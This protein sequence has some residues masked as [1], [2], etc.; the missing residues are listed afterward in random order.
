MKYIFQLTIICAIS[1]GAE[2]LNI[3]LPLPIPASVYGLV[4]L[5]L[6]LLFHVMKLEQ[7]E[8]VADFFITIMP[9]FFISSSVSLIT[10][11]PAMQGQIIP[12]ILM[13][14]I[15][16]VGTLCVTG[17]VSQFVIFLQRKIKGDKEEDNKDE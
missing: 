8:N 9:I 1:F 6:L 15:S 5:F 17:L 4:I 3:L 11:L 12:L 16:T 7:I 2:V 10:A 13:A 14:F